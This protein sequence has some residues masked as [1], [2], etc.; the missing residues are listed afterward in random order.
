VTENLNLKNRIRD[1]IKSPEF[2]VSEK[3][4]EASIDGNQEKFDNAAQR[5]IVN[6]IY[7]MIVF[8]SSCSELKKIDYQRTQ[9]HQSES[10]SPYQEKSHNF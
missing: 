6:N 4:I 1:F 10:C 8:Y 7:P 9:K 2:D 5:M 3:M